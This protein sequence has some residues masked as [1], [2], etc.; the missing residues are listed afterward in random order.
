MGGNGVKGEMTLL[1][2]G[3]KKGEGRKRLKR[4]GKGG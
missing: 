1:K 2:G 4:R 3:G